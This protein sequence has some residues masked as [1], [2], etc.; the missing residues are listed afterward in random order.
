MRLERQL[1]S[2][3]GRGADVIAAGYWWFNEV[4]RPVNERTKVRG[5]G[6][7]G[8]IFAVEVRRGR[9]VIRDSSGKNH[10]VPA[11]K[12]SDFPLVQTAV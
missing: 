8:S 3:L 10:W 12:I 7:E 2:A 6:N 9:V 5:A 1:L 11:R 4:G